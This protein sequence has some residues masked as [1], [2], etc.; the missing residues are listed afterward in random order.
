[1]LKDIQEKL[2]N[3]PLSLSHIVSILSVL[4]VLFLLFFPGRDSVISEEKELDDDILMELS[5]DFEEKGVQEEEIQEESPAAVEVENPSAPELIFI[6]IKGAVMYPNIY[7]MTSGQR[8]Y[9]VVEKAG[10]FTEHADQNHVNLAQMLQDEMVIYIPMKGEDIPEHLALSPAVNHPTEGGDSN[11]QQGQKTN[12]N[13]VDATGL[14]TL[15]G[16]GEKKA[17][18]IIDHREEEGPF[19]G[20][21]E[22]KNVS[23][24]GEKTYENL[25]DM[26]S[27][28]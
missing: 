28:D 4:L 8:L 7:E 20:I 21:E 26:I 1:M 27:V 22:I 19:K 12:I 13:T 16:I 9:D 15:N 24:I 6:D 18:M 23:G 17:Q 2:K 5:K 14:M 25:K 11:D 10:G 3:S